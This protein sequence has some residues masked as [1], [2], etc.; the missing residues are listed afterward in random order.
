MNFYGKKGSS[1]MDGEH[2]VGRPSVAD[3]QEVL[4]ATESGPTIASTRLTE[5]FKHSLDNALGIIS[6]NGI[7]EVLLKPCLMFLSRIAAQ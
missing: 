5:R 1:G 3:F 7:F 2:S 4:A 6:K